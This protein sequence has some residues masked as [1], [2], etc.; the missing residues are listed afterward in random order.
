MNITP[1][2]FI[3]SIKE[4][5]TEKELNIIDTEPVYLPSEIGKLVHY[6]HTV[7][8]AKEH[9]NTDYSNGFTI[10][11]KCGSYYHLGQGFTKHLSNGCSNCESNDKHMEY[12]VNASEPKYGGFPARQM[13]VMFD[14]HLHYCK[15][16]LQKNKYINLL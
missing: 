2:I 11:S 12:H 4:G 15:D 3:K 9:L 6:G 16:K 13:V 8:S 1:E 5:K 7:E 14:D 10:C